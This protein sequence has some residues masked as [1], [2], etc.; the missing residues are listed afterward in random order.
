MKLT[1]DRTRW[2]RGKST[3]L[4]NY[5]GL[6]CCLGFFGLACGYTEQELLNCGTPIETITYLGRGSDTDSKWPTW[7]LDGDERIVDTS[8]TDELVDINDS[9]NTTDAYKEAEIT[10]ILG[11]HGVEVE[12]TGPV[13]P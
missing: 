10:R 4:R 6:M 1:I 9:P 12:F 11:E 3:S 5:D 8:T 7:L 13:Q 2:N